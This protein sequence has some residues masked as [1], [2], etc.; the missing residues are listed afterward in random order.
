MLSIHERPETHHVATERSEDIPTLIAHMRR[1]GIPQ[2][3]DR[4]VPTRAYWGN[5]S[6]GWTAVVWLAHL[7]SC[8]DHKASTVQQWVS[9][10]PETLRWCT[11]S[12]VTSADVGIDQLHDVLIG[13]SHNARWQ[14][15]ET[16]L[17]QHALR[18][19]TLSAEQVHLRLYEGRSWH[20][21]PRGS[22]QIAK[23]HHRRARTLRPSIM[24]ATLNPSN[25]PL[26]TWSFPGDRVPAVSFTEMLEQ[27]SRILPRQPYRFVGDALTAIELRGAIHMRNGKYLFLLP[28][29]LVDPAHSFTDRSLP[30]VSALFSASNSDHA[31]LSAVRGIEWY[32]PA[33]AEIDGTTVSWHER[34]IAMRAPVQAHLL[35]ESLRTRLKRA[36][37][38]LLALCERKRGKRRLRSLDAVQ[39]AANAI[40]D[41]Y[42]VR[43]LLRLNFAEQIEERLVRRYRGRPTGVRV[44]RNVRLTV[45]T[46][47]DAL[48][49]ATQRLG[50][51]IFGSNIPQQ[52]LSADRSLSLAASPVPGFERLHGRPLSLT[53]HEVHT[54]EL[55]IGLIR[56]L[57]LGLRTLALL[58]TIARLQLIREGLLSAIDDERA[59]SR[60]TSERLL[61]AFRDIMLVPGAHRLPRSATPLSLLQKRVLHLLM[62]SPDIYHAGDA[63]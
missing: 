27:I 6:V 37:E 12:P 56:L 57:A 28:D 1:M 46:D 60:T 9:A 21:S 30:D 58:E 20:I 52:E 32:V 55:E 61:E 2:I 23:T 26:V 24:L 11:G 17:N 13:L 45:S 34:R 39:E 15:I 7:L 29:A 42:Q 18:T 19:W 48:T 10:H 49:R 3:L 62:L 50:W 40:L 41:S 36:E 53:P 22:L 5:L 35:E 4:H 51:Q 63:A 14:A 33:S 25:M 8:S 59:L 38:A 43:G 44:E 31:N 16:D 47:T 54:P